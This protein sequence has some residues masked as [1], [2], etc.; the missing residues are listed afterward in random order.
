MPKRNFTRQEAHQ[1]RRLADQGVGIGDIARLVR[2]TPQMLRRRF[3]DLFAP[4]VAPVDGV[5]DWTQEQRDLVEAMSGFGLSHDQ[6]SL[7]LRISRRQLEASFP[8]ELER[9]AP[10]ANARV[11]SSLFQMATQDRNPTAA[12]FWLKSRAGWIE[13]GRER[14]AEGAEDPAL[15]AEQ[16]SALVRDAVGQLDDAGRTAL[17]SALKQ[18]G[19]GSALSEDGPADGDP[20]H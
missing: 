4:G 18:L 16:A 11:A 2:T 14:G 5:D 12:I 3:A 20:V 6:I 8:E 13:A 19:A 7:V 1:I 10:A 9:G 17:R 15:A